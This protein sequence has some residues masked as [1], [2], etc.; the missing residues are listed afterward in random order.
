MQFSASTPNLQN[1]KLQWKEEG[2]SLFSSPPGDS[3]T[4]L[5]LRTNV[6][7]ILVA[8][9]SVHIHLKLGLMG[10]RGFHCSLPHKS[11]D[12]V[13]R[14]ELSW[15]TGLKSLLIL[16]LSNKDAFILENEFE[17]WG[18]WASK[19]WRWGSSLGDRGLLH[20]TFLP[21]Q[22]WLNLWLQESS[23]KNISKFKIS[24]NERTTPSFCC[25]SLQPLQVTR[26]ENVPTV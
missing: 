25:V 15:A 9:S 26:E 23:F 13:L 20:S 8:P 6:L 7:E 22:Q 16:W 5:S 14:E 24:P 10:L 1:L 18:R 3:E 21:L 11:C 2:Q 4:W 17:G 12:Q 19:A